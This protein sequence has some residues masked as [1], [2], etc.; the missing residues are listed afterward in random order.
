MRQ[1]GILA[2]A[3]L[4]SLEQIVPILD[5]DHRHTLQIAEG[6]SIDTHK[7]QRQTLALLL[8]KSLPLP[9][10]T[11]RTKALIETN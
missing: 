5:K 2:A 9:Q 11:Q 8:Q 4:C 6:N 1:A 7:L 3:G 10:R